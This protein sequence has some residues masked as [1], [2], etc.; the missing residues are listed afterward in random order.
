MTQLHWLPEDPDW[1]SRLRVLHTHGAENTVKAWSE[2]VALANQ[3][4]DFVRTNA[5]DQTARSIF[6]HQAP[7]LVGAR[8]IRLAILTS[9]TMA[10]LHGAI[11]VAG[12]RRGMW[13]DIYE[14]HH[15][16]YLQELL[17][18][19]SGVHR[20]R[21]ETVLLALD[22][23]HLTRGFFAGLGEAEALAAVE[24]QI[25]HVT[26]CWRLAREAFAC[27]IIHQAAP[28][29]HRGLLGLNEHRLRGSRATGLAAINRSLR[30][31]ADAE[32]V[33]LLSLDDKAAQQGIAA[34]HD[35]GLWHRSKQEITPSAAPMYGDLVARLIAARSGRSAKCLV[36]DLD[37]T[38]WGGVIGDD[39]MEGIV[40]GQGS[41]LGEGYAA[42]QQYAKDL[43]ARGIILAVCSKNDEANAF[44]AFDKHPEMLL[45]RGDIASFVANWT[46]K[47]TNLKAIAAELNIGIDSL[48]FIDDNPV[49]RALVRRE[50]PMVAVPEVSDDPVGFI[51][52]L[53]D[54]GYFE[55]TGITVEDRSRA[56]QY[57][58]NRAREVLRTSTTDIG[59][60]LRDLN[61]EMVWRPFDR[62]GLERIVQLINKTNQFN[63]TTKRY[64]EQ[65]VLEILDSDSAFGLQ[66]R[67]I[68]RFGDNGVIAICIGRMIDEEQLLI[69]TWLMS[70]RVLG[71]QVEPTTL[72]LVAEQS[73]RLGAKW[74][75]GEYIPSAKN[76]MVAD[77]YRR[78]GFTLMETSTTGSTRWR[79]D[80]REFTPVETFIT[81]NQGEA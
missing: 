78:L 56:S 77:H 54:G 7:E 18:P 71:R 24:E 5:L 4:I 73:R 76:G 32:G 40:L 57:Q 68:D 62:V 27:P 75:I 59:A 36:L 58:S 53:S 9:C 72:N 66:I 74:L 3:R 80:L 11:R 39:G 38:V 42:F 64:N 37:N 2:V 67:L 43:S 45:R 35:A 49:E 48:V 31:K 51:D 65:Q 15:G 46:D 28:P 63:L 79:I 1:R 33:D 50:L 44:E 34:W 17:D 29:V 60:Y 26:D 20:F 13:I 16:Q 22:G 21:P 12:F 41:P 61:M 23:H 25:I 10:H 14:N 6:G 70:C 81:V 69:D 47:P 8:P 30:S 19:E 52:A 55:S